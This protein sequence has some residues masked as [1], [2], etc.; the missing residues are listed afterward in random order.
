MSAHGIARRGF[1]R[2]TLHSAFER[3]FL[4]ASYLGVT[5]TLFAAAVVCAPA[6]TASNEKV[7]K[8]KRPMPP[9]TLFITAS[10]SILIWNR[11][12]T[13]QHKSRGGQLAI[14]N[15]RS[16]FAVEFSDQSF[17]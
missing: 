8:V 15:S 10:L 14:H 13:G 16:N 4:L 1:C 7:S 3:D 9:K 6:G 5:V 11:S 12:E 17:D 2:D